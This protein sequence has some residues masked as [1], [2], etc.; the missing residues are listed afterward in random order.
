MN[1]V[2]ENSTNKNILKT[3]HLYLLSMA[4]AVLAWLQEPSLH[5]LCALSRKEGKDDLSV[6]SLYLSAHSI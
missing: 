3:T 5:L 1:K 4:V 6:S 2:T